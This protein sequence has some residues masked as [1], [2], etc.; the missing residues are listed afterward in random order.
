MARHQ[1]H[2]VKQGGKGAGGKAAPAPAAGKKVASPAPLP[3]P[4]PRCR[5]QIA[6]EGDDE[7]SLF[8]VQQAKRDQRKVALGAAEPA[9]GCE[10]V[11]EPKGSVLQLFRTIFGFGH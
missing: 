9:I 1:H 4:A 10:P 3:A 6:F 8:S 11:E 7:F 5:A 2:P